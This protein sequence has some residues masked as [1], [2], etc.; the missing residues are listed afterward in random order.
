MPNEALLLVNNNQQIYYNQII[1]EIKKDAN[2]ILEKDTRD[3][4]TEVSGEVFLQNLQTKEIIDSA[5][6]T[7]NISNTAGLLWVL[8]GERYILPEASQSKC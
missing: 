6:S 4:Y 1:A 2:L 3:I 8:Y 7:K 5:S